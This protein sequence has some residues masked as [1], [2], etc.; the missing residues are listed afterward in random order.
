MRPNGPEPPLRSAGQVS[1]AVDNYTNVLSAMRSRIGGARLLPTHFL[2]HSEFAFTRRAPPFWRASASPREKAILFSHI[3]VCGSMIDQL[4]L[5]NDSNLLT[6]SAVS[7][8]VLCTPL[9]SAWLGAIASS[10]YNK[11]L[12]LSHYANLQTIKIDTAR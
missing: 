8:W 1:C 2:A 3:A 9:G 4:E 10:Q 11:F 12:C 6:G 5:P 7:W